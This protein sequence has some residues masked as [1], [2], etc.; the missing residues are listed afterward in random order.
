MEPQTKRYSTH[1]SPILAQIKTK[2]ESALHSSKSSY[3]NTCNVLFCLKASGPEIK[4]RE[5]TPAVFI[6]QGTEVSG[7]LQSVITALTFHL[8]WRT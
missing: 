2:S 3:A 7:T 5:R 8:G 6:L 1:T 4:N